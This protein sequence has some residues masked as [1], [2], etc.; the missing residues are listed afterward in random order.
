MTVKIN[1]TALRVFLAQR[2]MEQKDLAEK[3]G[4]SEQTIVRLLKGKPFTSDTLGKLADALGVNP[5]DLI[6]AEGY[7][8]PLVEAQA[9]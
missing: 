6:E 2:S 5:V 1:Q 3:S 8:S 7:A 9:A 4:V